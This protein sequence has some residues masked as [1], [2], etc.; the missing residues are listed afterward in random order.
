MKRR[1]DI[2]ILTLSSAFGLGY[3]PWAPGTWGTL[4]AIPIWW[5]LG[6]Q[7]VW[8]SVTLTIFVIALAIGVCERAE[9]LY[10][11]HDVQHIVLDEVVGL[12][13]AAIAVPF[14]WPEV[15]AAFVLFR[16][17]DITKPGGIRWIDKHVPGGWGVVLDDVAAGAVA[18]AIIHLAHLVRGEWW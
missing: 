6:T 12:L 11:R 17:L 7:P 10:G 4:V 1:S 15:I 9:R 2:V 8:L 14:R 13:T 16:T 3:L 18:C 5:A